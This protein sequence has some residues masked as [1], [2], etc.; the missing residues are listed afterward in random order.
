M[1]TNWIH[2]KH[3]PLWCILLLTVLV[4]SPTFGNGFQMEWDDQWMV[5]NSQTVGRPSLY[6]LQ[7]I[8]T[9]PSHGQIAPVN[10]ALYTLLYRGFGFNPLAYHT[11]CLILHLINISLLHIGLNTLLRDCT[12]FSSTRAKW[13]VNITTLL[14]A[15]HPLQVECV[16]WI[17]ASKIPLSTTFY[18]A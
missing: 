1:T 6:W 11:A 8:F 17:S 14:F 18:F 7:T 15:I 2:N 5:V 9:V 10:Q 16:A 4:F 12:K 13:I 3:I